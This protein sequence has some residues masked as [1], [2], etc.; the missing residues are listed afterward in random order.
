MKSEN[1]RINAKSH[2]GPLGKRAAPSSVPNQA[3]LHITAFLSCR[4]LHLFRPTTFFLVQ[5]VRASWHVIIEHTGN[6]WTVRLDWKHL[7]PGWTP[8]I[9]G[10]CSNH[11]AQIWRYKICSL[12]KVDKQERRLGRTTAFLRSS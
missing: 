6:N 5:R 2:H 4:A 10:M 1:Q 7:K 3:H 9:L 11:Y 12:T 8:C